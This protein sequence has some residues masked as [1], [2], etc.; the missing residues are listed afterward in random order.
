[1]AVSAENIG[2]PGVNRNKSTGLTER[3]S[4]DPVRALVCGG[5]FFGSSGGEVRKNAAILSVHRFGMMREFTAAA[6]GGDLAIVGDGLYPT[7]TATRIDRASY[8][9][10]ASG[11]GNDAAGAI[12]ELTDNKIDVRHLFIF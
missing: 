2:A 7:N 10:V 8:A 3:P 1:M 6:Y 5:D 4:G 12:A 9:I 11:G